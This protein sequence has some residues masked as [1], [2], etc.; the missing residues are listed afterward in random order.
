[1]SS[2]S[3]APLASPRK[4]RRRR[5]YAAR[6]G[7]NKPH[8]RALAR[9]MFGARQ[10]LI[11]TDG[12]RVRVFTKD[13]WCRPEDVRE[14]LIGLRGVELDDALEYVSKDVLRFLI[15]KNHLRKDADAGFYW[16][17]AK[18]ARKYEL[19]PVLGQTFPE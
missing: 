13:D 11:G 10:Y 16:I 6:T 14:W 7:M 15:R 3:Q 5:S 12:R 1:M 19:P 2:S 4:I 17:T 18:A 8:L 9:A